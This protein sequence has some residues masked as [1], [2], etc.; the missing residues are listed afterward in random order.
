MN[1]LTMVLILPLA[2]FI[3]ALA[4][5]RSAPQI[6]RNFGMVMAL[7]TFVA[8]LVLLLQLMHLRRWLLWA[9]FLSFPLGFV[10]TLTGWFTAEVGRQPWTV[11]GALRTA[12]AATPSLTTPQ[13]AATLVMFFVVYSI[14]FLFGTLYI[15][16]L[17]RRGPLPMSLPVIGET[18]PKRP[19]SVPQSSLSGEDRIPEAMETVR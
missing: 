11:F 6:S 10:A 9:L 12:D 8:S 14:I 13:V 16:R 19:L 3:A 2:G 4:I 1:I 15:Y 17:L 5:P 7:V 18:N